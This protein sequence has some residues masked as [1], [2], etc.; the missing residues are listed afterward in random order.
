MKFVGPL[1]SGI[2]ESLHQ[3]TFDQAATSSAEKKEK[4]INHGKSDLAPL[5]QL[6]KTY[7][8]TRN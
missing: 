3:L 8:E 6:E 2:A 7:D 5:S 4:K 1:T